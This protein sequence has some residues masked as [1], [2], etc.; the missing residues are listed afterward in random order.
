LYRRSSCCFERRLIV[1]ILMFDDS[2]LS[3]IG[4]LTETHFWFEACLKK[5]D[6]DKIKRII[7]NS[8]I[9]ILWN[10]YFEV[11][12]FKIF[13][14][15]ILREVSHQSMYLWTDLASPWESKESIN[16]DPST[17]CAVSAPYFVGLHVA[18]LQA[19]RKTYSGTYQ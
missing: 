7:I 2:L 11:N 10:N 8:K 16:E 6:N 3:T 9:I 19:I 12:I 17:P 5:I 15:F 18:V 1:Q 14:C 4:L 13:Y